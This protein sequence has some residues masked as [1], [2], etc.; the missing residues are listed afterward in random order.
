MCNQSYFKIHH[1]VQQV[2]GIFNFELLEHLNQYLE[3]GNW[4]FY[5][6]VTFAFFVDLSLIRTIHMFLWL[7]RHIAISLKLCKTKFIKHQV[8]KIIVI[9]YFFQDFPGLL[10]KCLFFQDFPGPFYSSKIFQE[11]A[12]LK[13]TAPSSWYTQ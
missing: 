2:D 1:T 9:F 13:W 11:L 4:Y 8:K 6:L 3:V 12:T 5:C 10:Q 7:L